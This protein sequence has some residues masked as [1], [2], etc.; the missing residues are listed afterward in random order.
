MQYKS[1]GAVKKTDV[2]W[3]GGRKQMSK[4]LIVA[5]V[6]T[7]MIGIA[8]SIQSNLAGTMQQGLNGATENAVIFDL[9][10]VVCILAGL[11]SRR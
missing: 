4:L 9:I 7:L 1:I 11:A 3:T 5:G 2:D 10:G 8:L 6:V